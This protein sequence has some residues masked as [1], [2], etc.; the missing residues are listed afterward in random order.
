MKYLVFLLFVFKLNV[1]CFTEL[2]KIFADCN[3]FFHPAVV[4]LAKSNMAVL[5][6]YKVVVATTRIY[7]KPVPK[8]EAT[9]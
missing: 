5:S 8:C 1:K 9:F 7:S 6:A 4:E 2:P 3:V